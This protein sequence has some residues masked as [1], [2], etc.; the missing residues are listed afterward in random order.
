MS[1]LA[2]FL[3]GCKLGFFEA[4]SLNYVIALHV[5]AVICWFAGLFYLPRLFVYHAMAK[6]QD[7]SEQFKIMEYKLYFYIMMPAMLL[8]VCS[9]L[10]LMFFDLLPRSVH[11]GW[12][13]AKLILV[14]IL[15][16]FHGLCGY[17]LNVFQENRNHHT[18]RFYRI[19]NEIPTLLLILIIILA[20]T[21]PF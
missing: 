6:S 1:V 8:S 7:V 21:Q 10:Y 14:A 13:W 4:H 20:M 18:D 11:L 9:G 3:Q 16:V 5:I 15:L 17:Y 12:F 2:I 19:F